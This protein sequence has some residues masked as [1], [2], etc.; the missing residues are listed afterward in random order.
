[1]RTNI[2]INSN[3]KTTNSVGTK[4]RTISAEAQLVRSVLA[5]MLW[6]NSFYEDGKSHAERIKHL[7]SQVSPTFV[8][9]L[10]KRARNEFKLRHVPLKLVRE[11]A[12]NGKLA[13][14]QLT[15]A[16]ERPDEISEFLSIYWAEGRTPIANQVKKGL[17]NAFGKFNEFQLSKWDKNSS[18][19]SLRDV[20]FMVHAN[21]KGRED[22]FKRIA[23]EELA[24]AD[25]WETRLSAGADKGETFAD[26][27]SNGKLGAMAF[28]RNLRNM[29]EAGIPEQMI[30]AY[31]ETVNVEK[32]LPFRYVAAARIMPQFEDMLE[33]MMLRSLSS[34]E[35]LPGKTVLLVD[36][37][38]SM[39]GPK[40]SEKSDLDR[41]DAAAALAMLCR[42]V[43]EEV[44][45]YSY[46][47]DAVRVA[48]RHGFALRD[49]IHN[50]QPHGG[51]HLG[52]ALSTV[53]RQA[54][55][56]RVIVFT[57]EQSY[58]RVDA[59]RGLGYVLNVASYENGINNGAWTTITG[60]SEAVIDYIRAIEKL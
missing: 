26:L 49:A 4:V 52:T 15:D 11:L 6:E 42:E 54:K 34:Q 32:V 17:A 55:Y 40:V 47:S 22:L 23:N 56:D 53:N 35:K 51:T 44:E 48:P 45:I 41:F 27:M 50:S 39:F 10:A 24:T 33:K 13:A 18:A 3:E 16:I 57:D 2:K 36:V 28:L 12:R 59:P 43:C 30:R 9:E 8:G 1:M 31:A 19:I 14:N 38:G 29:V 20:M 58:D 5:N 25:T 37:S 7:V 60:F 21:P 46:S